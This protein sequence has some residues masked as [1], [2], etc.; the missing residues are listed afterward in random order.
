M[1][2][3]VQVQEV[4]GEGLVALGRGRDHRHLHRREALA[5][6]AQAPRPLHP[7]HREIEQRQGHG[8]PAG[9][10]LVEGGV[11]VSRAGHA[12]ETLECVLRHPDEEAQLEGT[13]L[14]APEAR[15]YI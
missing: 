7:G 13:G 11:E 15:W 6:G 3:L 5:H 1:K 9:G 12:L 4:D 10:E 2:K 8:A 14:F